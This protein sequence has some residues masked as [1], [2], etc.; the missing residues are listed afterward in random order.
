M[1]ARRLLPEVS[2]GEFQ[3]HDV[4]IYI[5][6]RFDELVVRRAE[7]AGQ[8]A[9]L[10][11]GSPIGGTPA[12]E[13]RRQKER[14]RLS[15]KADSAEENGGVGEPVDQPSVCRAGHPTAH[16]GVALAGEEETVI[17]GS[18]GRGP[19]TGSE[20]ALGPSNSGCNVE[21]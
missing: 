16:Q 14:R 15:G 3:G 4:G 17:R 7:E 13:L 10:P 5:R 6:C 20:R 18:G 2:S 8:R 11:G 9:R 19:V 12:G 1:Q 21:R